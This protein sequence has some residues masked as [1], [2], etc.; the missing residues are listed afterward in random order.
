MARRRDRRAPAGGDVRDRVYPAVRTDVGV[1]RRRVWASAPPVR[2]PHH[3][4]RYRG[5]VVMAESVYKVVEIIGSST[6]SWERA[7][8][9]AV[10]RTASS[11]EDLRVA[12]IVELDMK[13]EANH[14]V[15]YRAKVKISFKVHEITS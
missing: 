4:H 6:E 15:A 14:V 1:G 12:E 13:L 3:T 5:G 7:A 11:I 8:K 2:I 10:D 9:A